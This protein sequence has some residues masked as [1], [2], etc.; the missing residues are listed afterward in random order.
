MD[1]N[2]KERLFLDKKHKKKNL[3]FLPIIF[4]FFIVFS[5]VSNAS[6]NLNFYIGYKNNSIE[7][8]NRMLLCK[9]R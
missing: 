9:N 8:E 1:F 2:T 3:I 5:S 4:I 6:S 7:R